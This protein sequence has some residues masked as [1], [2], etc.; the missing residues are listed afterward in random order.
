M[1]VLLIYRKKKIKDFSDVVQDG[2]VTEAGKTAVDCTTRYSVV[3]L[4]W[5]WCEQQRVPVQTGKL[6]PQFIGWRLHLFTRCPYL[7]HDDCTLVERCDSCPC[8]G[9]SCYI[10]VAPVVCQVCGVWC[11]GVEDVGRVFALLTIT[12]Y[13]SELR[14]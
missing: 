12:M 7:H 3:P 1:D 14:G 10:L 13:G 5:W 8:S 6:A 9:G 11:D 4:P 2:H